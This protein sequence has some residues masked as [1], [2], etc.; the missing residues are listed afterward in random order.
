MQGRHIGSYA[1]VSKLGEGGMGA[2]Y[3]ARHATLG[4]LAAVKV[5]LPEF[6]NNREIVARFFNEARAA[7]AIRHPGIIEV[8]DFGFLDEQQAYIIM[9][10]LE[11]ESLGT[12]LRRGPLAIPAVLSTTRGIA[13]ALHAAHEKA[14]VHR[15]LKPDNIFLVPDE[16]VRGGERVKLLDFG[17]A[18]LSPNANET[19]QT[20][21]GMVIG[22]PTY[23][24]PEQCRGDSIDLRADLYALGCVI[25]EMLGGQPP[26][27]A[28]NSADILAHH[29][30]F[31]PQPVSVLRPDVPPPI[32]QL[33]MSLLAKDP[34]E[35]PAGAHVV[36]RIVDALST[37]VGVVQASAASGASTPSLHRHP[38]S[39]PVAGTAP[40][41]LAG[42]AGVPT[43][44]SGAA[45]SVDAGPRRS[46]R[47]RVIGLSALVTVIAVV[48]AVAATRLSSSGSDAS[49][50][51]T[52]A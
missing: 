30:Y 44:L 51:G 11:G 41:P 35:R 33:V 9:E 50:D 23:M 34:A 4:R 3:L 45:S 29:L 52:A 12:R 47:G 19:G 48:V 17:I 36:V 7:T 13:R 27:V 49:P 16:D 46:R 21:T 26:F 22:T 6:S 24:A 38:S 28:N 32:E 2:V 18:K 25:Y 42:V 20:R 15:D 40:A 5:L 37:G 14:I 8:Y 1:I 39:V 43:T 31:Q 10:Y